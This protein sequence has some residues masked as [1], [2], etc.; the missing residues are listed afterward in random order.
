MELLS[1][2][3]AAITVTT[4]HVYALCPDTKPAWAHVVVSDSCNLLAFF[5]VLTEMWLPGHEVCI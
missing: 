3:H 2:Y 1:V 5:Q 4:C